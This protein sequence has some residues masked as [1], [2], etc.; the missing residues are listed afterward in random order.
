MSTFNAVIRSAVGTTL[1][2]SGLLGASP[3]V[4]DEVSDAAQ[5]NN[6]L[7]NMTA[8]NLQNYYI[9]RLTESDSDANQFWLRFAKPFDVAGTE[10]LMRASLPVNTFPMTADGG[11]ATGIGDLNVLTAYLFDTGN[12]AVSFGFGPQ[13]TA[14][15]APDERLGSE[16]WSAGFA[17][18]L[19]DGRSAKFQ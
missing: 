6:P 10:W 9:G 13:I 4:A 1:L 5:A 18:V 14:P 8:F 12:P 19:F 11:L 16:Q 2:L 15:T 3:V 7:A 17:N